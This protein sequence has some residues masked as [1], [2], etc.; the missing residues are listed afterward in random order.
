MSVQLDTAMRA[1]F[2]E[3]W[4]QGREDTIYRLLA[5]DGVAHGLPGGPIR[6]PDHFRSHFQVFRGAFPD[7]HVAVE[8]TVTEGEFV[9]AHCRVTGTHQGDTLGIPPTGKQVDFEGVTIVKMVDGLFRE[10]WNFFDFLKMYQQLGVI[11]PLPGS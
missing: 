9:V 10:G 2:D 4:T 5:A 3:V 6:G 11:P 8:R 7:I 1:W